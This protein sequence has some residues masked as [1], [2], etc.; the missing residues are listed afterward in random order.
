MQVV[1]HYEFFVI[2]DGRKELIGW[3]RKPEPEMTHGY[4]VAESADGN[5]VGVRGERVEYFI[6]TPVYKEIV[7]RESA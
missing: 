5:T 6:I 7:P 1:H 3:L 4:F 2:I